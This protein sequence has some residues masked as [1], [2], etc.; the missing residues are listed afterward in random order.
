[1]SDSVF[2]K[3][4]IVGGAFSLS[5]LGETFF[6]APAAV[7][8]PGFSIQFENG[9]LYA[10]AQAVHTDRTEDDFRVET[11][12][13]TPFCE[14]RLTRCE[15]ILLYRPHWMFVLDRLSAAN[16]FHLET[17]FFPNG[18]DGALQEHIADDR[19]IVLRRGEGGV[20]FFSFPQNGEL[21]F[22]RQESAGSPVYRYE[23]A[24][25]QCSC[26]TIWVLAMDDTERVRQWHI[27]GTPGT[28]SVFSPGNR[29]EYRL[30]LTET[31]PDGF[32]LTTE[33]VHIENE[34]K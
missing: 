9:E 12:D 16:P 19:R 22:S 33:E 21:I 1:M 34:R 25:T 3:E 27:K 30:Q 23:T 20:T 18:D 14:G 7:G 17:A 4:E 31:V 32:T 6:P 2:Q 13:F 26:T 24:Q 8:T 15:R 5:H 11:L 10:P 28:V 29:W